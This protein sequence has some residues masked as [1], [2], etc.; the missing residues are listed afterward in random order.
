M[1]NQQQ[2]YSASAVREI[3]ALM[4]VKIPTAANYLKGPQ[5]V[6]IFRDLGFDDFYNFT[7]GMGIQTSDIGFNLSRVDYTFKRLTALNGAF[8]LPEA[9][10]KFIESVPDTVAAAEA[11][12]EIID[13][14]KPSLSLGS[15]I[16]VNEAL[17]PKSSRLSEEY[18]IPTQEIFSNA[19]SVGSVT[20]E[21]KPEI[22]NILLQIFG[23]IPKG[24]KVVFISYSWDSKEHKKWV[25]KLA[26]ALV[27]KGIYTLLDEYVSGGVSLPLFMTHGIQRANKVLVIGTKN[28]VQKM[29]QIGTGAGFEGS[30]IT[31]ALFENIATNKFIPCLRSG[32]F[33]ESFPPLI[34]N[35]KG[36]DFRDDAKF[37]QELDNLS[38]EIWGCPINQRPKLGDIPDYAK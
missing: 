7:S 1:S 11:I 35:S 6:D 28:Y 3:A 22:N 15:S 10:Q 24:R 31:S 12:R 23:D 34:K 27:N 5:L 14:Y 4:A 37:E 32:D 21:G 16:N 26:D 17:K 13:K 25:K 18:I 20:M 30:I 36:F 8:R 19:L 9:L 38:R 29:M 33:N 2:K